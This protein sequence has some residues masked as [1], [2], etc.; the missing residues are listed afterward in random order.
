MKDLKP[1]ENVAPPEMDTVTHGE[2]ITGSTAYLLAEAAG[3]ISR[4]CN[5][6]H[7]L[8]VKLE[9]VRDKYSAA[10][11]LFNNDET[12]RQIHIDLN[13]ILKDTDDK[14]E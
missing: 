11:M 10:T 3:Q 8:R 5:K 2:A 14:E 13:L 1:D 7:T 9:K 4:L 12:I 6:Y